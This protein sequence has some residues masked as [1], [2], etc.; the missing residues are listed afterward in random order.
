MGLLLC[1]STPIHALDNPDAPDHI[2]DFLNRTQIHE[3]DIL[4]TAH[5]TQSYI[6]AYATY[7]R[8][9]D[10]ELDAVYTQLMQHMTNETRQ[11]LQDSQRNWLNYRD[12]E[13][14]FIAHNWTTEKFGSSAVISRGDYRT[15]LIKDRVML[16]LQYLQNY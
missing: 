1:A 3:Q 9:L 4:R 11:A 2:N 6:T 13:F 7:E 10:K 16:L 12:T 15:R 5:T 14:D 8:F